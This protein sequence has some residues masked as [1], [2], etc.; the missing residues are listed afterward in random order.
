MKSL[1]TLWNGYS[2]KK[3]VYKTPSLILHCISLTRWKHWR[4]RL[5]TFSEFKVIS[6]RDQCVDL[7]SLI[8][9][10]H[11]KLCTNNTRTLVTLVQL[12]LYRHARCARKGRCNTGLSYNMLT[13]RYITWPQQKLK[14]KVSE[15]FSILLDTVNDQ[16]KSIKIWLIKVRNPRWPQLAAKIW[17]TIQSCPKFY[18]CTMILVYNPCF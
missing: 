4:S 9:V 13:C 12:A 3:M 16:K 7:P 5:L 11:R 2:V 14:Q 6:K 10:R 1:E 15:R 18:T 17:K 8:L